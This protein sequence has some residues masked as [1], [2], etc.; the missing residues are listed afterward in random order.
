MRA[1]M[2]RFTCIGDVRGRGAMVAMELVM[3]RVTREPAPKLTNQVLQECHRRGLV[4]LKAGLYDNVVRL[5][6]SLTIT[7]D[8]LERGLRILEESLAVSCGKETAP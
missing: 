2:E 3:D 6:F 1:W 8:E 5:L 4:I 7:E